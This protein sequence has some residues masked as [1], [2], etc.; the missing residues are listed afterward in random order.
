MKSFHVQSGY[1]VGYLHKLDARSFN[2]SPNKVKASV[3]RLRSIARG[4]TNKRI[5]SWIRNP[6]DWYGCTSYEPVTPRS[7]PHEH[8][9]ARYFLGMSD[10]SASIAGCRNCRH[11]KKYKVTN[12]WNVSHDLRNILK[13]RN[14]SIDDPNH[15]II[16][17][18]LIRHVRDSCLELGSIVK[19]S[20]GRV[21]ALESSS[22][23]G[24][25]IVHGSA[26]PR[27]GRGT[28]GH[29]ARMQDKAEWIVEWRCKVLKPSRE[30]QEE[31]RNRCTNASPAGPEGGVPGGVIRGAAHPRLVVWPRHGQDGGRG[32]ALTNSRNRA[33][34]HQSD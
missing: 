8:I 2:S 32:R 23:R 12:A 13:N 10:R 15:K 27:T 18:C 4:L 19:S 31:M 16:V 1:L 33:P 26:A 28:S 29:S 34:V 17:T 22:W 14:A 20:A 11:W 30:Q 6:Q 7:G 9:V 24:T 21:R 25:S 5:R 3:Q